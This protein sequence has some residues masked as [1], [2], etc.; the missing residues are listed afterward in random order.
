MLKRA[1]L[2]YVLVELAVLVG[3]TW[4]VGLGWTLL[5]L[6][7]TAVV[8]FAIA[9]SQ[10]RRQL[11]RLQEFRAY[12]RG[13]YPRGANPRGAVADSAL[14][15]MGTVLVFIPGL[16]SSLVGTLM[17]LPPTRSVIRPAAGVLLNRGLLAP[18]G[19]VT[20]MSVGGT[21][22]GSPYPGGYT[23]YT[24]PQP[25]YGDYI[26]GEVIEGQVYGPVHEAGIVRRHQS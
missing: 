5:V 24:D 25:G 8:G 19:R 22:L 7:A 17:L 14:I 2:A 15:A 1:F 4:A 13:A 16:L 21:Y 10:A 23:T 3:L 18:A 9:G 12:P 6:L 20:V 26:D 11:M